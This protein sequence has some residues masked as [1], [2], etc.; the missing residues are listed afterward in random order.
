MEYQTLQK[1]GM[2]ANTFFTSS[3]WQAFYYI[4]FHNLQARYCPPQNNLTAAMQPHIRNVA[5]G[6]GA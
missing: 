6:A 4:K 3:A 1:G 2:N 5:D